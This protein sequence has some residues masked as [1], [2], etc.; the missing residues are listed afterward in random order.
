MVVTTRDN[1]QAELGLRIGAA[2][3]RRYF[4][5][6]IGAVDLVLGD[7]RIQCSLPSD[8]WSGQP[9][10]RDPRLGAW[11]KYKVSRERSGRKPVALAMEKAGTNAFKVQSLASAPK[12]NARITAMA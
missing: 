4:P 11:L 3:A 7:L 8:F 2:N 6:T 5:R 12:R 9:E 1:G 10:I